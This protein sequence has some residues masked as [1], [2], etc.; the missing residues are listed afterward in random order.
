LDPEV[1]LF[2]GSV[3]LSNQVLLVGLKRQH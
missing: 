1:K 2:Y 3:R